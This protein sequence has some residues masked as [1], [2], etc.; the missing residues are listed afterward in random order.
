LVRAASAT[1]QED[2]ASLR[3]AW[4]R[5]LRATREAGIFKPMHKPM[6]SGRV[7]GTI[8]EASHG[9][10]TQA[11]ATQAVPTQAVPAQAVPVQGAAAAGAPRRLSSGEL[12]R[13]CLDLLGRPPLAEER[14]RWTDGAAVEVVEAIVASRGFWAQ[15]L[16]E[17]LWYF[18]LVDQFAP[19]GE[20]VLRL[21]DELEAGELDAREAV[22][23]IALAP[24]FDQRNP[25]ADTFVTVVMEQL[26][27][28]EVAK[29]RRELELGKKMYEG[30]EARFLGGAGRS[31]SDV[32]KLAV[33][34]EE[35]ARHYLA[36]EHLRVAHHA[37]DPR[38]LAVHARRFAKDAREYPL[39]V[40]E[41]L[42][43]ASLEKRFAE[44]RP[45][46]NRAWVRALH[47][48]LAGR[49]PAREELEPMRQALDALADPAPL[50]AVMARL[51]LDGG[52]AR[53]E[54]PGVDKE[55]WVRAR[56]LEILGREPRADELA[57]VL[58][59]LARPECRVETVLFALV[60][61][62]EATSN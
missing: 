45:L 31:Q 48:D 10:A 20:G 2:R 44:R 26:C 27:G 43:G 21:P 33:A 42:S 37:A 11:V 3:A 59:A 60:T 1:A 4:T 57:G 8:R 34:S 5:N 39:L 36:R 58:E 24:N 55:A 12:R 19:R 9:G 28:L 61:S 35:F 7:A 18:L 30:A 53:I 38:V 56:W 15:W 49:E 16:D 13:L 62:A 41:W 54:A 46:S 25:G 14:A 17:Q 52:K 50:R 6:H 51:L 23:R 47:V 29:Q 22:H 32:V 40:R